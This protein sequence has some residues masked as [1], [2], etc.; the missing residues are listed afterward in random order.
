MRTKHNSELAQYNP[1]KRNISDLSQNTFDVIVVGGGIHGAATAW[2]CAVQG[3]KVALIE[4]KD[5]GG[6]TSA[7]S[8]KIIHGGFR[9][10]QHL[11][12]KRM[13]ESIVSRRNL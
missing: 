5:F 2:Q 6:V 3:M 10:L 8:L 4:K 9:Y 12:I 11:N 7:N 1:M 13:R